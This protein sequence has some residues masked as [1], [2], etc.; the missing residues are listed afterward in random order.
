MHGKVGF[1]APVI[2]RTVL[3]FALQCPLP[4]AKTLVVLE[5][6]RDPEW[7]SDTEELLALET[8]GM[9]PAKK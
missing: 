9:G 6:A 3:R 8:D 5:R 2:R 1:G 4:A 7:V